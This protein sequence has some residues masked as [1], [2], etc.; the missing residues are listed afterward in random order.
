[1]AT[2]GVARAPAAKTTVLG[3]LITSSGFK[4]W[5]FVCDPEC[6]VAVPQPFLTGILLANAQGKHSPFGLA[7]ALL[8]TF[9]KRKHEKLVAELQRTSIGP[10][11]L[12]PNQVFPI[13]GLRAILGRPSRLGSGG[14]F[15]SDVILEKNNGA[16]CAF[17]VSTNF[18]AVCA[19]LKQLYPALFLQI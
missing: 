5:Y 6:I 15:T 4:Y 19:Q 3:P 2:T 9:G 1:M 16:K 8:L 14:L 13:S 7:G 11:K 18:L 17:G 10:L 12:A